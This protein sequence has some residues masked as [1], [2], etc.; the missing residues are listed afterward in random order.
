[1]LYT[2]HEVLK[3]QR[4]MQQSQVYC[5]SLAGKSSRGWFKNSSRSRD[6]EPL[7][8]V[9]SRVRPGEGCVSKDYLRDRMAS[10]RE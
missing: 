2:K 1:M 3:T 7:Q 4:R 6:V 8:C 9:G 5:P 10:H